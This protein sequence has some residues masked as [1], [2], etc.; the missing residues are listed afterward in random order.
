M[1]IPL[2]DSLDRLNVIELDRDIIPRLLYNC[3]IHDP[4]CAERL[5][6]NQADVL[7]FDFAEF[8]SKHAEG[9]K[10]RIVG[11]LPYNISTPILFHLLG[12]RHLISDMHFML[13]K[14]VVDRICSPPGNK[15]YGRLSVMIQAYCRTQSLFG[16]PPTAFQPPPKVD[17]AIVQLVPREDDQVMISSFHDFETLVRS[18]FSQRRKTLRNTLR[19]LCGAEQIEAAGFRPSQRAEELSV[20]DFIKLYKA[21]FEGNK[22]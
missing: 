8:H 13:Q 15:N 16:V 3:R 2:L 22:S 19:S 12:F 9:K 17:S 6:V 4:A 10:L 18:A 7:K 21:I 5:V 20:K 1:T 11:N 14:E